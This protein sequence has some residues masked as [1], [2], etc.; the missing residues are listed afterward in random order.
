MTQRRLTLQE[1]QREQ[2]TMLEQ[3]TSYCSENKIQFF[4]AY[5]SLLGAIRGGGP[6]PWD[7]DIDLLIPRP[8]FDRLRELNP[9]INGLRFFWPGEE[10]FPIMWGKCVSKRTMFRAPHK[11]FPPDYGVFIDLFILDGLP[12][13]FGR[14]HFANVN[15]LNRLYTLGH[16][17]NPYNFDKTKPRFW[18]RIFISRLARIVPRR[19]YIRRLERLMRKHPYRTSGPAVNL[20]D[21]YPYSRSKFDEKDLAHPSLCTF[22]ELE[23]ATFAQPESVLERTY[24]AEWHVPTPRE[25]VHHGEAFWR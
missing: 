10:G 5:G 17:V 3:F 14:L 21:I 13:V 22:S 15:L 12:D 2:L 9:E 11:V 6:I 23:V 16:G 4:L 20:L 7:D 8:D 18:I 1:I 25:R 19:Y 24:G